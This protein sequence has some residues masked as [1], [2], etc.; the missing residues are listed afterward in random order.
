MDKIASQLVGG[1]TRLF[2][3]IY[4]NHRQYKIGENDLIS[5][6]GNIPVDVG[7][8]IK[9]EKACYDKLANL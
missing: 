7:D 9:L 6:A 4:F 8:R 5:V 1:H 3:V 2:A